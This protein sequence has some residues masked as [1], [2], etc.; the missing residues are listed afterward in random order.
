MLE[1]PQIPKNT[2]VLEIYDTTVTKKIPKI[3]SNLICIL[4]LTDEPPLTATSL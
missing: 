3:P 4:L 2:K 1:K